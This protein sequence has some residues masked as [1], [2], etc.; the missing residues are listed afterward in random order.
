MVAENILRWQYIV[1]R[2]TDSSDDG[3]EFYP[4]FYRSS[5][6]LVRVEVGPVVPVLIYKGGDGDADDDDVDVDESGIRRAGISFVVCSLL[7]RFASG[8]PCFVHSYS[9]SCIIL[10]PPD[11]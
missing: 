10:P 9:R 8:S 7:F 6:L 4:F 1:R 5:F 3:S 11:Q 2:F